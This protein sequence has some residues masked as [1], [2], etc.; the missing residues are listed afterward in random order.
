MQIQR[1]NRSDAEKVFLVVQNVEATTATTGLAMRYVGGAV[2]EVVSAD[3]VQC[4]LLEAAASVANFSG[5]AV[6]DIAVN[7]YGRVQAWGY[8]TTIRLSAI[9][10]VTVGV[11]G[12]AKA[13]LKVGG[14]AGTWASTA[15]PQSLST[16]CYKYVQAWTTAGISGG[17]PTCS[18]FV[19]AL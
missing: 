3:G 15:T 8:V 19:R 11:E 18:G 5:I 17:T 9:A 13:F 16:A 2:A 10:D 4:V 1:V 7:G 12:I 14:Q 6:Q